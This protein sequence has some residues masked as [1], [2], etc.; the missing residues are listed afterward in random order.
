MNCYK[1]LALALITHSLSIWS[2]PIAPTLLSYDADNGQ[3]KKS[4]IALYRT[5][6]GASATIPAAL[7]LNYKDD[8][9][10]KVSLFVDDNQV[11][12]GMIIHSQSSIDGKPISVI[13]DL[14]MNQRNKNEVVDFL[15]AFEQQK[16]DEQ[17]VQINAVTTKNNQD[18]FKQAGFKKLEEGM[19][20]KKISGS[21]S[22][23][24]SSSS[25]K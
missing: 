5:V 15:N 7:E 22:S 23:N 12:I 1:A 21:V 13:N 17:Y 10:P 25:K 24:G 20:G 2:A 16:R 6:K 11:I 14:I 19:M 3:L 8:R 4:A 9:L 18:F